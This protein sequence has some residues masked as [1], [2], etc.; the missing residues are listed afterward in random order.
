[1][2]SKE[3]S[4]RLREEFWIAFG[5]S[6]PHKWILYNTKIKGLSLK[7]HFELKRAIV[8]LDLEHSSLETRIALWEK[9]IALKSILIEE[10]IPN[11][12][13]DDSYILDSQKEISRCYIELLD[14]SIHNKNTWRQTM[15]FLYGNMLKLEEFFENYQEVLKS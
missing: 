13:F 11:L 7:F 5:K 9:L 4:K 8:S 1:M 6:Y 15:E 2:F 3:E 14:V 12:E 10:Y